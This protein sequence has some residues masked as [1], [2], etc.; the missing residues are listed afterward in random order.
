MIFF[1]FLLQI[2]QME[3]LQLVLIDLV[4]PPFSMKW[5]SPIARVDANEYTHT[6]FFL[7][8]FSPLSLVQRQSNSFVKTIFLLS[9]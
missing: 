3:E 7:P 9:H 6:Y 1:F 5:P 2:C 8:N 4:A